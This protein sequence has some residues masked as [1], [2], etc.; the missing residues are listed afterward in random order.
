MKS[1]SVM[2]LRKRGLSKIATTLLALSGILFF[3]CLMAASAWAIPALQLYIE[4]STYDS[5]SQTWV[6]TT[7]SPFK[8]WVIGDVGHYGSIFDLKLSAAVSTSEI[9][10]S[11]SLAPATATPGILPPPG[12]PSTPPPPIPTANFPSS[13]GAVPVRG[14][15]SLLPTHGIYRPGTSF[16]EWKL[17]DFTLKDSPIGDVIHSFPATFPDMGQINAYTVTV[18]GFT[19]VHFDTYDHYLTGDNHSKFEFAPF[20]HDAE[21]ECTGSCAPIPEPASLLLLG[22]GLAGLRPWGR[23][24]GNICNRYKKHTN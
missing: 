16:F 13:D 20:S 5:S 18:T 23:M 7:D 2:A 12:D 10:G 14:D 9:P 8:L 15:G 3:T 1:K 17:G 19:Q 24:R 11:I 6:V 22:S 21:A 4:G